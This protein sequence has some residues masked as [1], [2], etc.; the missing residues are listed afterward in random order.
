MIAL[1]IVLLI[2]LIFAH[3]LL[4]SILLIAVIVWLMSD[5]ES[6]AEDIPLAAGM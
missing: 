5:R 2:I 1:I 3:G 4:F 6:G